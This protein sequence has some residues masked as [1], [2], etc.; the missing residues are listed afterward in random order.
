MRTLFLFVT[1][2]ALGAC[3]NNGEKAESNNDGADIVVDAPAID[4]YG[5]STV[6]EEG[7]MAPAD[8]LAQMEGKD[9]LK[10][11]VKA[12]VKE[13]CT[14][15]GCWMTLDMG[16]GKEMHVK[17]KDYGF[18]VPTEGMIGKTVVVDGYAYTDTTSVDD[19]RH[20]AED[21]KKSD[22]EIA[23]ITQPEMGT[24]FTANGVII[25]K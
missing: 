18:F 9:T 5:D 19:L 23:A 17:F 7:A 11:K 8:F 14:R 16:N 21:A 13:A 12:V 20:L 6:T 24:G 4:V 22:A 15:K 3:A 1:I 10:A 25:E 2:L